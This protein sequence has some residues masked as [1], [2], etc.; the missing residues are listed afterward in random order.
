MTKL[1][2]SLMEL[3]MGILQN[4]L[5]NL[6][7]KMQASMSKMMMKEE[8]PEKYPDLDLEKLKLDFE[9]LNQK[10]QEVEHNLNQYEEKVL[11]ITKL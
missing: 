1:D 7:G 5:N 10:S 6:K 4:R 3:H 2:S 9:A 8:S 11:E